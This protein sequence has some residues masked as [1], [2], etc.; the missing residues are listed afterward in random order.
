MES[1]AGNLDQKGKISIKNTSE[2]YLLSRESNFNSFAI[3][4]FYGINCC[5]IFLFYLEM[6]DFITPIC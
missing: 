1:V 4:Q 3:L 6:V 2:F 5:E